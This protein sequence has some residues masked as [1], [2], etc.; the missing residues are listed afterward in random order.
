MPFL[1]LMDNVFIEAVTMRAQNRDEYDL[2]YELN[3]QS[4]LLDRVKSVIGL[5]K[6]MNVSVGV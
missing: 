3:W 6:K 1:G 4:F 2:K 5:R